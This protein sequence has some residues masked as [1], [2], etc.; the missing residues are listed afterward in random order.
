MLEP[1][2]HASIHGAPEKETFLHKCLQKPPACLGAGFHTPVVMEV[3]ATP[4][5]IDLDRY[6][7]ADADLQ[8][9]SDEWRGQPNVK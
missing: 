5:F 2:Y 4:E 8:R 3:V 9:S 6:G 1:R 7:E